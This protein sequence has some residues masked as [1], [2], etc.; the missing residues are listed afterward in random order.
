M[1]LLFCLL[2]LVLVIEG[3]PYFAFP[4]KVKRWTKEIQK[5]PNPHLRAMGFV[6]MCI[7]LIMAYLF[8]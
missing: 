1:K 2:G 8:R 6:A 4:D 3:L 5:L 7:G